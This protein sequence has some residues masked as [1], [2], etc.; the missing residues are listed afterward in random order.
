MMSGFSLVYGYLM[1]EDVN[2]PAGTLA[3]VDF[4]GAVAKAAE[5]LEQAAKYTAAAKTSE[6][7]EISQAEL[8]FGRADLWLRLAQTLRV[9]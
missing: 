7:V 1:T 4:D 9:I 3:S 2:S 8:S 5:S 6:S